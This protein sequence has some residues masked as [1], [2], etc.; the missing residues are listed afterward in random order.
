MRCWKHAHT[1]L[2][3]HTT[4]IAH[5]LFTGCDLPAVALTERH[6]RTS[7][8]SVEVLVRRF[9]QNPLPAVALGVAHFKPP[10]GD[11]WCASCYFVPLNTAK[12]VASFENRDDARLIGRG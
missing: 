8:I 4:G 5:K 11:S 6:L 10:S 3:S 12:V 2:S 1:R 7:F 9:S